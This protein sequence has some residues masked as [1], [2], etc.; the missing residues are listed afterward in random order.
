[1]YY[2]VPNKTYFDTRK[3]HFYKYRIYFI[4]RTFALT[5]FVTSNKEGSISQLHNKG[6]MD[7]AA[8]PQIHFSCTNF[9]IQH[10]RKWTE[11]NFS[12]NF[13]VV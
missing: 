2:T 7:L 8:P 9:I 11:R 12:V 13:A 5:L 3:C 4:Q 1:M 6:S 10:T